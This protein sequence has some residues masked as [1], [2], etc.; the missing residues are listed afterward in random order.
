MCSLEKIRKISKIGKSFHGEIRPKSLNLP[1]PCGIRANWPSW[2]CTF[3][4]PS[5]IRNKPQH[6]RRRF[7]KRWLLDSCNQS[8]FSENYF[9]IHHDQGDEF[10]LVDNMNFEFLKNKHLVKLPNP[11]HI[12]TILKESSETFQAIIWIDWTMGIGS[13]LL[14]QELRNKRR[15]MIL[16]QNCW[17]S[18]SELSQRVTVHWTMDSGI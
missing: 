7:H 8:E 12:G 6:R 11:A 1:Y 13:R 10:S 2:R 3:E 5:P 18:L 4:T 15:K 14:N 16:T 9:D 17:G